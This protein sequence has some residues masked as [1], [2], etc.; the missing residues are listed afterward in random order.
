[1]LFSGVMET[2]WLIGLENDV[3]TQREFYSR[4]AA[5]QAKTKGKKQKPE[6]DDISI[7][8]LEGK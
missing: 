2:F 7:D 6:P 3:Q 8:S 4:E 5:E 1:M